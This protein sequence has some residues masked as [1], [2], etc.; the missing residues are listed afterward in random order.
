MKRIPRWTDRAAAANHDRTPGRARLP[1]GARLPAGTR[2]GPAQFQV[3]DLQRSLAFYR[4]VL[5]L[6][7]RG[8][9]AE[10]AELHA[11]GGDEP[12]LILHQRRGARAAG[13]LPR[14]GLYHVALL[15]PERAELARFALHLRTASIRV[16]AADHLVSEAFYLED[17]DGLG[18]EIYAD[19]PRAT[20]R[21]RGRE[22]LMASEPL[23]LA[24]LVG[25]A[26]DQPWRGMPAGAAVGHV[27]L[28]VGDLADAEAFYA[29]AIGFEPTVWSYPGALF[30]AAGGYHH[31]LGVNTWAGATAAPAGR[32]EARLLEWTLHLPEVAEVEKVAERLEAA[33]HSCEREGDAIVASDPWGTSLRVRV[34]PGT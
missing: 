29:D 13:R 20:W 2:L 6:E 10:R 8:R 15:L 1:G 27:H 4:S 21:R 7:P 9:T 12:L 28:H 11:L 25:A 14:W 16:G 5:G 19:R 33:G 23:E 17:P 26:G 22:L 34:N 24:G 32:D 18:I 3:A 31:H 30:L